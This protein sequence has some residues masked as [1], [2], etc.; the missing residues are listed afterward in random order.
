VELADA[1]RIVAPVL[2]VGCG[3]G[4][5]AL[6]LAR[7]G[8]EVLGIDAAPRAIGKAIEKARERGLGAEFLLADALALGNL[9]RR[10]RTVIDSGLFHVFDDGER[11]VFAAS[12]ASVLEP[13][14]RYHLLCFNEHVPGVQGPRRVTQDEIRA[15]FVEPWSVVEIV[16][17]V[18]ETNLPEG[19]V[20][21]WRA[22]IE[23][24]A[25][26]A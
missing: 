16:A 15:T 6:E 10:F 25:E 22:T 3:T 20:P 19:A 21:A 4:E 12:L 1:G 18:F 26:P 7:R 24:G 14:G 9:R 2:D 23:L 5:N 13:G 17:T 11:P 8:I